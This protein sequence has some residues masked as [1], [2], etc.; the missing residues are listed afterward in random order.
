M[1]NGLGYEPRAN[2]RICAVT[3]CLLPLE[4]GSGITVCPK[5]ER[6]WDREVGDKWP[7]TREG[8]IYFLNR[9]EA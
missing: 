9:A 4:R 7:S 3:G 1:T 2:G 5:H 6:Q 8:W